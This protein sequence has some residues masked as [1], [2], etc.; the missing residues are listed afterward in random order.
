MDIVRKIFKKIKSLIGTIISL[1]I[2]LTIIFLIG[3]CIWHNVANAIENGKMQ[4]PGDKIEVYENQYMHAALMGEGE[5]TVVFLPGL[6]TPSPYYDY[7]TLASKVAEY[8]KVLI[9]EPLGYGFSSNTSMKRSL[10]NYDYEVTKILEHYKIDDN[11]V[12]LGHSYSGIF[13]LYYANKNIDK[14]KNLE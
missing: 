7:Y 3:I 5:Y 2:V 14:V 12:L 13:N 8:S 1:A 4:M 11:I 10:S 9:I 6:G